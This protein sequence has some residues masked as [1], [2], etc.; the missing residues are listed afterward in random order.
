[1]NQESSESLLEKQIRNIS[2]N[3]SRIINYWFSMI[4]YL[5]ES[6][7]ICFDSFYKVKK[8]VMFEKVLIVI[9]YGSSRSH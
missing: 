1:M 4:V 8:V 3:G 6:I 2:F 7:I 9:I 5:K